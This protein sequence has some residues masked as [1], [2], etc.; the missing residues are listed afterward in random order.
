MTSEHYIEPEWLDAIRGKLFYYP[1]AGEDWAEPLAVFQEVIS[2]FW[3]CD[4]HYPRG[5][6]LGIVFGSDPDYQLIGSEKS[7]ASCAELSQR[8][9]EDGRAYRFMEPSKLSDTYERKDGRRIT[10]VR[11]RGFGQMALTKEFDKARVGGVHAPRRQHRR[12]RLQR[13]LSI[14]LQD[15]LRAVRQS[16]QENQQS[17]G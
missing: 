11:R 16:V 7:G 5:L 12:R 2:T 13:L 9:A 6:R 10:V 3:F 8:V 4:I 1:A 17:L 14:E 15:D